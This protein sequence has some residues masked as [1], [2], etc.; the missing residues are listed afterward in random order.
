MSCAN[1]VITSEFVSYGHPDKIADQIADAILDKFIEH[2]ANARCGIEV[3]VKDNV[4]VLGGEVNSTATVDYDAVVRTVFKDIQ[5]PSNHGLSPYKIKVLNLIGKQSTEI[6]NGVD[7]SDNEIGAGDQGFAVGYA[8]NETY[9]YMPLGHYIAK[10]LCQ[11][12]AKLKPTYGPD[13]KTQVVVEY[14]E[15]G[16]GEVVSILVSAM[17]KCELMEARRELEYLIRNNQYLWLSRELF[18]KYLLD[19]SFKVDINP[20]GSWHIGGPVSDCG[21]T[22]RKLVVDAYGG[23]CNIGGGAQCGKDYSKV[24]RSAAYMCRYLAK[25]IVAS[26]I[27]DEVKVELAYMI[28][29]AQ[30]VAL[31]I[32]MNRNQ[33]VSCLV[34]QFINDNID[35][36]PNGIMKRFGHHVPRNYFNTARGFYGYPSTLDNAL[37]PWEHIDFG[38]KLKD[39]INK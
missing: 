24:D 25:N 38:Y 22:G 14:D 2:D 9:V 16:N 5:F 12:I 10:C 37:F 30:P 36:T 34:K 3:M 32:E 33:E 13:V 29:V 1:K 7:K 27:A 35:L 17:H 28:S 18:K 31:N 19:K 8:T 6:H 21:V 15:S 4:V 11:Y 23:Y 39:F 20:C 26:G